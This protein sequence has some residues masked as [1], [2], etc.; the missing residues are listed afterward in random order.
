MELIQ[1]SYS[2]ELTNRER[3]LLRQ[4]EKKEENGKKDKKKEKPKTKG[5][6][7]GPDLPADDVGSIAI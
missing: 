7:N 2:N 4:L 5:S 3:K 1:I 6:Q